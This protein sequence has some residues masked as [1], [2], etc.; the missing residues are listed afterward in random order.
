LYKPITAFAAV[1][2]AVIAAAFGEG[3]TGSDTV[4][5]AA[6]VA[7]Y[8]SVRSSFSR[9]TLIRRLLLVLVLLVVLLADAMLLR[10]AL[11]TPPRHVEQEGEPNALLAD[12]GTVYEMVSGYSSRSVQEAG[13]TESNSP[14][15]RTLGGIAESSGAVVGSFLESVSRASSIGMDRRVYHPAIR[16][17]IRDSLPGALLTVVAAGISVLILACMRGLI[18]AE[19]RRGTLRTYNALVVLILIHVAYVALGLEKYNQIVTIDIADSTHRMAISVPYVLVLVW[20]VV[21]GFRN[22]WIHYLGRG[23]KYVAMLGAGAAVYLSLNVQQMYQSGQLTV[24]SAS[25]GALAGSV[26]T[27]MFIYSSIS[28]LAI[29]LHLPTAKLLDSR[30]KELRSL[31]EL[32]EAVYATLDERLIASR[33]TELCRQLIGAEWSWLYRRKNGDLERS[34][35]PHD[36]AAPPPQWIGKLYEAWEKKDGALLLNDLPRSEIGA[37]SGEG[38]ERIASVMA[39]RLSSGEDDLGILVGAC[40]KRFGFMDEQRLLFASFCRQVGTALQNAGLV[41]ASIE[42]ERFRE[43]LNLARRIQQSLLPSEV[44]DIEGYDLY[45]ASISCNQ[46]GGDY[47][48]VIPLSDG[49]YAMTVADVA[50]KGAAGALLMSALQATLTT[51]LAEDVAVEDLA[52]RLNQHLAQR[53]PEDRFVTFFVAF[54]DPKTR[55][56]SYCNAGHNPPVLVGPDGECTEL[57][58]GGL[59]MGMMRDVEYHTGEVLLIPG[60]KLVLYTDGITET[61]EE[62]GEE[63]FGRERLV[64]VVRNHIDLGARELAERIFD[65]VESFRGE[66]PQNDDMT[67]LVLSV[68]H[69]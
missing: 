10:L 18:L 15:V 9:L 64:G 21:N 23:G 37:P 61:T 48:D 42:R 41:E 50:G 55:R 53:M 17:R 49:R 28:V 44:P 4:Y 40:R 2:L 52:P 26:A 65:L 62:G 32:S 31:Q 63:E 8:M 29:L 59:V 11:R 1:V 47:Y 13:L 25:M 54:I 56:I 27:V 3:F 7:F 6:M 22:K 66:H 46:V 33:A 68:E 5:L 45:A 35:S 20:G 30:L 19:R 69:S 24:C 38:Q 58:E 39:G 14:L 34:G 12:S 43:E 57:T 36:G 16:V 51:L 60:S 67:L